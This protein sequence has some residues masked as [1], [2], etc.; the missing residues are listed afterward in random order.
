METLN[1]RMHHNSI[2]LSAVQKFVLA[3]IVAAETP[4]NAYEAVSR[5]KNTVVARDMLTKIGLITVA[6]NDAQITEQGKEALKKEALIDEMGELTEEGQIWGFAESPEEAAK[7]DAAKNAKPDAPVAAT[8]AQQPPSGDTPSPASDVATQD[9][10][11]PD[12]FS[13]ESL[14]MIQ[15]FREHLKEEAFR[16]KAKS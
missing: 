10:N 2:Q 13:L 14:E 1:E 4:L 5:G 15:G 16:K 8:Q 3:K 11:A 6:E 9:D 12:Q 7:E